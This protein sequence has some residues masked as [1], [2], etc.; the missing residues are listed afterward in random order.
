[1]SGYVYWLTAIVTDETV[2]NT[3]GAAIDPD[4][5]GNR[6]W[7]TATKLYPAGTTF[8]PGARPF[9]PATPSQASN[10]RL[11]STPVTQRGHD[12]CAEFFTA[13]PWPGLNA[14][15]LTD[16]QIG[17]A[18]SKVVGEVGLRATY[19]PRVSA[20]ITGNGYVVP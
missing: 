4:T 13:G 7:A 16:G 19:E 20:V 6:T 9:D 8:N 15:G 12:L 10:A 17:Y 5:G 11:V 2:C 3:L 14:I 1:M 18:K